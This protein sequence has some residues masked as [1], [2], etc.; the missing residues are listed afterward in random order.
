MTMI[1]LR[2]Q[3]SWTLA[4][5][6]TYAACQWGVLIFMTKLVEPALVGRFA[7]GLAIAAPI[8]TL[9]NLQLRAI[10]ATD[11]DDRFGFADYLGLRLATTSAAWLLICAVGLLFGFP[12][13]TVI[14][15]LAVGAAKCIEAISDAIY[16]QLQ[17][18]ERM[19]LIALSMI[20]K[21]ALSMGAMTLVL[22]ATRSVAWGALALAV[23]WLILLLGF[24]AWN[25]RRTLGSESIRPRFNKTT[26]W[27]L[28]CLASP[29]GLALA[30]LGLTNNIPR[31]FIEHHLGEAQLGYFSALAYPT[32]AFSLVLGALGQAATPRMAR[33]Y[34][35]DRRQFKRLVLTLSCIP[36]VGLSLSMG[37]TLVWGKQILGLLY[38]PDYAQHIDV[39]LILILGAGLWTFQ[40][41]LGY[42][43]TASRRFKG[44]SMATLVI[45]PATLLAAVLLVP[46]LG[47]I[48]AAWTVV[49]SA[50]VAILGYATIFLF[51]CDRQAI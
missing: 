49:I 28:I 21:G 36:A 22:L 24:D 6:L 4:G 50:T 15:V 43:A 23:A 10:Q 2:H 19:K 7:L 8:L 16:G 9:T 42:A 3:F 45:L 13:T 47:L 30:L 14:V 48:G 11:A 40:S 46:A 33:A 31:Y 29:L 51:D 35:D 17:K 44:Q 25:V 5:N 38:R 1:P 34:R 12:Q 32:I 18:H 26:A 27:K 39:F 37:I 41:V 20:F